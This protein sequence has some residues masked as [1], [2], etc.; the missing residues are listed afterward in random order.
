LIN[1]L[2][3]SVCQRTDELSLAHDESARSTVK[4]LCPNIPSWERKNLRQ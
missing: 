1:G 2:N 3:D 4:A